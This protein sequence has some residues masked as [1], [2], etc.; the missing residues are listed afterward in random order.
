MAL[1]ACMGMKMYTMQVRK[2]FSLTN[3]VFK[4]RMCLIG[5]MTG[6]L[7]SM[8]AAKAADK[9]FRRGTREYMT[10]QVIAHGW[11]QAQWVTWSLRSMLRTRRGPC[12]W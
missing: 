7:A 12:C 11:A 10:Q 6:V 8:R 5:S 9:I 3:M 1:C 2:T 4:L